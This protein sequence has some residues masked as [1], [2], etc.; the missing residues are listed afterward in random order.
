MTVLGIDTSGILGG[1]ALARDGRLLGETRCDARSAASER[2]IPQIDR[3]L[4]DLGVAQDELDRL[5]VV[6]GPGSFTGLRVAL[7]TAKGLAL[8]LGIPVWPVSSIA[9]RILALGARDRAVLLVT[10]QRRGDVFS[11][12][13]FWEGWQYRT[14]LPEASRSMQAAADW[15]GAAIRAAQA[16]RELPLLCVGDATKDLLE[17]LEGIG[18]MP[19]E[20]ELLALPEAVPGAVPGAV[21]RIA[22]HAAEDALLSG[23]AL[24]EIV[25]RYLRGSDARRPQIRRGMA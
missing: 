22:S 18:R 13:G 11:G 10:A 14:L 15:V 3:L 24:D 25:P 23:V 20:S 5:G 17:Q 7:G 1:V 9:A 12:V 8:G 21:A 16:S 2:M 19:A 6:L 4:S